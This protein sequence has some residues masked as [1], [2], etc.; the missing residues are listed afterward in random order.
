MEDLYNHR[1][2]DGLM[3]DPNSTPRPGRLQPRSMVQNR[4]RGSRWIHRRNPIIQ[5][6]KLPNFHSIPKDIS[7]NKWNS[8]SRLGIDI[9]ESECGV[10]PREDQVSRSFGRG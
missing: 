1:K 3:T 10:W 7:S 9:I 2:N 6:E 5:E 8:I 4:I